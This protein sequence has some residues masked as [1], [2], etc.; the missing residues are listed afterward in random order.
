MALTLGA[1]S[2]GGED[3]TG[4]ARAVAK[5]VAWQTDYPT[6]RKQAITAKQYLLIHFSSKQGSRQHAHFMQYACHDRQ[7]QKRMQRYNCLRLRED[8][9]V[10]FEGRHIVLLEDLSFTEMRATEGLAVV[11]YR[12]PQS[13]TFG[14]VV[15]CLPFVKPTYYAPRY[16]S[17]ASVATFLGLPPGSLTQRMLIYAVRM[18]PETP[19]SS[20][21]TASATLL[22]AATEHCRRQASLQR[23][24]HQRWEAR[25]PQIW[26]AVGGEPPIEVCAESWSDEPL[27]TAC[28]GCVHAWR[29][30]GGHW[31]A[32]T[33]AYPLFGYDICR[34]KDRIWYATGI[35]G[36]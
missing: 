21:G 2:V 22:E 30:S 5:P 4:A 36:G 27:L 28:L 17:A 7:V 8:E 34:G 32:V 24:G 15:G 14:Q 3:A 18:H 25:F 6:A 19:Q 29:Q 20:A 10:Q 31:R 35:F 12:D 1:Q 23:Q 26:A 9:R 11:D 16:E 13:P 33:R